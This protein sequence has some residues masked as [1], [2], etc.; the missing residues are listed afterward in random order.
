MPYLNREDANIFYTDQGDGQP[1]LL[2]HG[3]A[4]DSHDW[5][6]QIPV[7]LEHGLRVIAMDHR[8]HG[9][10]N[11]T[12]HASYNWDALAEDAIAL[13][14][15]LEVGPVILVGHS[16]STCI[17]SM[18][19]AEHG[20]IV[21]AHVLVHPIYG[22]GE[23]LPPALIQLVETMKDRR[24]RASEIVASWFEQVM[25]TQDTPDWI[26]TWNHR[27]V[28]ETS[29]VTLLGCMKGMLEL[30]DK[31]IGR[32]EQTKA[33]MRKRSAPRLAICTSPA[34]L[35]WEKELGLRDEVDEVHIIEQGTFAHITAHEEV[36]K[37]L[38]GWLRKRGYVV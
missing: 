28:L 3:Y 17:T 21:K 4:C 29:P 25:Y 31:V 1:V 7:L 34:A 19:A 30:D 6:F 22:L 32:T 5:S 2:L 18:I 8:G 23:R 15:S 20:G 33:L 13:V 11:A 37:I 10:S 36:N 27:R 26:R 38:A 24:D 12:E 14:R 9:R 16:M 35:E